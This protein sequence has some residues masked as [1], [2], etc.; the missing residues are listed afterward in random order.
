MVESTT[1][2]HDIPSADTGATGTSTD[3]RYDPPTSA[4]LYVRGRAIAVGRAKDWT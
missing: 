4:G 3:R 2:L 1:Q